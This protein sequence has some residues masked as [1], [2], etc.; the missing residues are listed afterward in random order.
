MHR[1][2]PIRLQYLE[3]IVIVSPIKSAKSH[4]MRVDRIERK[5][6]PNTVV[7]YDSFCMHL[8]KL[9]ISRFSRKQLSEKLCILCLTQLVFCKL[10]VT[11]FKKKKK[12][13]L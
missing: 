3:S 9:L 5:L 13:N 2:N 7:N 1:R 4:T 11:S 10:N 6:Q 12:K 8:R